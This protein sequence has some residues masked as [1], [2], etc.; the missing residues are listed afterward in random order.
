M[1]DRLYV[2]QFSK[3]VAEFRGKY[4][5]KGKVGGSSAEPT[6][7]SV[8]ID[9]MDAAKLKSDLAKF[10]TNSSGDYPTMRVKGAANGDAVARVYGNKET[11]RAFLAKYYD[12]QFASGGDFEEFWKSSKID[13]GKTRKEP[14]SGPVSV[15]GFTPPT[16]KDKPFK[17]VMKITSKKGTTTRQTPTFNNVD[18]WNAWASVNKDRVLEVIDVW[19][20]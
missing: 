1:D 4:G 16:K 19:Q 9:V 14:A 8:T 2:A 17:V 15:P 20:D 11:V 10:N 13:A 18:E 12:D 5:R 7:G 6:F 3:R